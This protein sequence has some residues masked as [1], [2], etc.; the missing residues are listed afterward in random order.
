MK[1]PKN[2]RLKKKW[3]QKIYGKDN[4]RRYSNN[5][6]ENQAMYDCI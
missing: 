1:D 5:K 6:I 3:G 2:K 4:I